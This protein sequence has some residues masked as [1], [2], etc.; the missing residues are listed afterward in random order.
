MLKVTYVG[1]GGGFMEYPC[2]EDESG[3]M[4]FDL[5]D[6]KNG[7]NLHTGAYRDGYGEICG[8]PNT[9]ITQEVVCEEPFTRHPKEFEYRMLGRLKSDCDYFLGCG[10]GCERHLWG[11]SVEKICDEMERLWNCF[12]DADKPEWL[13]M[14]QIKEYREEMLKRRV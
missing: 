9:R 2:Y 8:E 10:N 13:T 12:S 4:H 1:F 7:L 5:N 11:G 14:E 3:K 6:G